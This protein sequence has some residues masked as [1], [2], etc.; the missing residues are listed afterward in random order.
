MPPALTV[1]PQPGAT[2]TPAD[3]LG[4]LADLGFLASPDLPD[5]PGPASLLVALRAAL[6]NLSRNVRCTVVFCSRYRSS[7]RFSVRA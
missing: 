7:C 3:A 5:R 1:P 2:P 4:S 6:N